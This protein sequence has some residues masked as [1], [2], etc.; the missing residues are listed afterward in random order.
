MSLSD[1]ERY[2]E[3]HCGERTE[4]TEGHESEDFLVSIYGMQPIYQYELR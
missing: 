3:G 2:N 4:Q 1:R